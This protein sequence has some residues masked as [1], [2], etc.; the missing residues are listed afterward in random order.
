MSTYGEDILASL[1]AATRAKHAFDAAMAEL[2]AV[3]ALRHFDEVEPIRERLFGHIDSFV[4]NL[5][6]AEKRLVAEL[7]SR[8]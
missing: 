3:V 7:S 2:R 1:N 6:A 5:V 4:D 8:G